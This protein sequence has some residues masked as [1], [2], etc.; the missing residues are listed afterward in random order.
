MSE[1]GAGGRVREEGWE[2]GW[3]RKGGRKGEG[4]VRDG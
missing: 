4:W 3:G 1:E 2:E